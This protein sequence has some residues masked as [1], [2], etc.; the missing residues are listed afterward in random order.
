MKICALLHIVR[1]DLGGLQSTNNKVPDLQ[2]AH[3]T[4]RVLNHNGNF[5]PRPSKF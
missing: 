2:D 1:S 4:T 3:T 5:S